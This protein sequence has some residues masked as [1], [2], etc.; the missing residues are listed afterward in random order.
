MDYFA[1]TVHLIQKDPIVNW[2]K[3]QGLNYQA[4]LVR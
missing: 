4:T 2:E 1:Q 3:K